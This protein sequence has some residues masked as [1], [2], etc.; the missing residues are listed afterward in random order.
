MLKQLNISNKRSSSGF[1]YNIHYLATDFKNNN[2]SENDKQMAK[3]LIIEKTNDYLQSK[4]SSD[5]EFFKNY[6]INVNIKVE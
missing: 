3:E 6:G 5:V 1:P 2:F 4:I